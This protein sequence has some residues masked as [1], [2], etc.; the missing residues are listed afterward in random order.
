MMFTVAYG[1]TD[2]SRPKQEGSS[3]S[4]RPL[5]SIEQLNEPLQLKY[6]SAQ[7]VPAAD[8]LA[9]LTFTVEVNST[10]PIRSFRVHWDQEFVD[11]KFGT[12]PIM[13]RSEMGVPQSP[14]NR[15]KVVLTCRRDAKV[16]AWVSEVEFENG[17]TWKAEINKDPNGQSSK[18]PN[19]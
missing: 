3:G 14:V 17:Q 6:V 9:E 4:Q 7:S 5:P 12:D 10:I 18:N 2:S 11:K 8:H 13:V 1:Q 16:R 19:Q 15:N